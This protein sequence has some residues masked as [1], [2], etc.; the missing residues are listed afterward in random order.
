MSR[1]IFRESAL[2]HYNERLERVELPRYVTMPWTLLGWALGGLLFLLAVSL[3][4]VRLP[5]Y[6]A[7]PGIVVRATDEANGAVV[8]A[9]LPVE[10]APRLLPGQQAQLKL[11][12]EWSR[13]ENETISAQVSTVI[14][15]I[16]S[17]T[18]ARRKYG[19]DATTGALIDGPVAV[20]LIAVDRPAALWEGSVGEVRVE[21]GSRSGLTLLP[22]LG[23]L[24]DSRAGGRAL[25]EVGW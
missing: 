21:V 5:I 13:Q 3:Q 20:A 25:A 6:A 24:L 10:F 15:G 16:L 2:R 17:P 14:P 22:G 18:S 1:R 4:A 11:P 9:L 7:G 12:P 8:A 23:H 19:L